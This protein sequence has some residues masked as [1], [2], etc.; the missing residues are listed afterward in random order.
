ML[1][2]Y[3]RMLARD[4]GESS[5]WSPANAHCPSNEPHCEPNGRLCDFFLPL[6]Q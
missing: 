2:N 6:Y 4:L 5:N 1:G 3:V